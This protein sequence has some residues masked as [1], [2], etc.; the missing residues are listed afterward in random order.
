MSFNIYTAKYDTSYSKFESQIKK[1][2][3]NF[4][5]KNNQHINFWNVDDDS[6]AEIVDSLNQQCHKNIF[7]SMIKR[8]LFNKFERIKT[9]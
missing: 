7:P 4:H 5:T 6:T 9:T 2:P 1:C 3:Q 8:I